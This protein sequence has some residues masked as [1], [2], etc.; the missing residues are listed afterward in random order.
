MLRGCGTNNETNAGMREC[1]QQIRLN[2]TY[3]LRSNG[4]LSCW[5]L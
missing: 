5:V 1:Q 2:S 4:K 3:D